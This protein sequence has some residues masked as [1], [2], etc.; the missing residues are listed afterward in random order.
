MSKR[1]AREQLDQG[2]WKL[3]KNDRDGGRIDRRDFLKGVGA[4]LAAVSAGGL[5][6]PGAAWAA[7]GTAPADDDENFTQYVNMFFDGLRQTEPAAQVPFG[8]VT[9]V[10]TT[11]NRTRREVGR[12]TI[13]GF[14]I[15]P[16][17]YNAP[18]GFM[19]ITKQVTDTPHANRSRY[20]SSFATANESAA[21]GYYQVLL[22]D[23]GANVE[24]AATSRTAMA[25]LTYPAGS[26]PA[27]L[28][29]ANH[30]R[31]ALPGE[32]T[33]LPKARQV[34][35][36]SEYKLGFRERF[37]ARQSVY[38]VAE[39]DAPFT[40][41]GTWNGG[42]LE[43]GSTSASQGSVGAYVRFDR[44]NVRMKIGVSYVSVANARQNLRAENP[45]WGFDGIRERARAAWN[46]ALGKIAV[47]DNGTA[48]D[49]AKFYTLLYTALRHPHVFGDINGQYAGAD[50]Q[51]H[52]ARG[53]TKYHYMPLWDQYRTQ[54][55][56]VALLYPDVAR[57][58]VESILSFY[59]EFG[60]MP[61]YWGRTWSAK[62]WHADPAALFF[63]AAHSFGAG[64]FDANRA[65]AA[66]IDQANQQWPVYPGSDDVW[67]YEIRKH[68]AQYLRYGY[69]ADAPFSA[70]SISLEFHRADFAI[71]WLAKA[72][73]N[74]GV[75]R[76]YLSR[77]NSWKHLFDRSVGWIR[78]KNADGSWRE[79]YHP[80]TYEGGPGR[81]F[82]EGTPIQYSWYPSYNYRALFD[83]M[84]GN[85][86][87][88][89]R[90]D[91]FF[92]ELNQRDP[93][94]AQWGW[95]GP[96]AWMGNEHCDVVPYA[97]V[98]AGAPYRSQ[99][100]V[101]RVLNEL[102][103][104]EGPLHGEEDYGALSSWFV[105]SAIG[106]FPAIPGTST[107]VIGAP[108]FPEIKLR[109]DSGMVTITADGAAHDA[110][111]VQ[112]LTVNRAAYNRAWITLADIARGARLDFRLGS[113]PNTSWGAT[114]APP[115][116][117][118]EPAGTG[119]G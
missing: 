18:F 108:L 14:K 110:A 100:V 74:D 107:L 76:E 73:G 38:F 87:V 6:H 114:D 70:T 60:G 31:K 42:T 2:V 55:P 93:T 32:V 17:V 99:E 22:D 45:G 19:P 101:R 88:I 82:Y 117:D 62:F 49:K 7:P 4:A 83:T 78:P 44:P 46:R 81:E 25:R 50:G 86:A 41:Y 11:N 5:V 26:D 64:G 48:S 24:L 95:H 15:D 77:A 66:L 27:M 40:S 102:Y 1:S 98:W 79:A 47:A 97:A 36:R 90:L 91:T 39:F 103:P 34:E 29:N 72:I 59:D 57:D 92:T 111:Y 56:L 61:V 8:M 13:T 30:D 112:S 20:T 21:P 94:S 68:V 16:D 89:E 84:G 115:C 104:V 106:L 58:I 96:H 69:V 118:A 75:Y 12:T 113:S 63:S 85:Q 105:W 23:S 10:A 80:E 28:I 35:G 116:Y 52:T 37:Q 71:A 109:L 67:N 54:F 33:I 53:Y 51:T 65:L 3:A 43:A 119:G 9:A